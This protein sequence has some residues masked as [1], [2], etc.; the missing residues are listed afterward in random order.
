MKINIL[1]VC[2]SPIKR[3][4]TEVFLEEALKAA[5]EIEGVDTKLVTLR[6]T[7]IHD[8]I[9]CNWCLTKQ[10]EGKFCAQKDDMSE[11][12]PLLLEA[13]GLL[14]ASPVYIGR[15]SG[16]L[17]NFLDRLRVFSPRKNYYGDKLKDKVG[18]ALAV[19]GLRSGGVETTLLSINYAFYVMGML[20]VAEYGIFLG[21][22]GI[23][24][25][26]G[27]GTSTPDDR[28]LVLKDEYGLRSV[29]KLARRMVEIITIIKLGKAALARESGG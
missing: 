4:N 28:H 9:H 18:G 11:I 12:Y 27:T 20:P 10:E 24:S 23:S 25:L 7:N 5:R 2:G 13:D 8:C 17:A 21:A 1:G 6:G 22:A 16:L 19:G 29:R 26:R 3:G 15:L 14:L